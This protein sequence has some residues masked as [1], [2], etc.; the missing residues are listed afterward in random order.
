MSALDDAARAL[1]AGYRTML[2]L[3]GTTIDAAA[4]AAHTPSGPSE[5]ELRERI[6]AKRALISL[7]RWNGKSELAAGLLTHERPAGR[8]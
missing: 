2:G 8:P 1:S 7:P 5:D 4:K 3:D 6:R